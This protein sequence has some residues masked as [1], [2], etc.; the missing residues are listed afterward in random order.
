[1]GDNVDFPVAPSTARIATDEVDLRGNDDLVQ[2]PF[3]KIV[4]GS[5][6]GTNRLSVGS[7]GEAFTRP[8]RQHYSMG[9]GTGL[10]MP[11]TAG[12]YDAGDCLSD[13][14]GFALPPGVYSLA[15]VKIV[16]GNLGDI[17][18]ELPDGL[19]L[20]V[21]N[22]AAATPPTWA[23]DGDPF[24]PSLPGGVGSEALAMEAIGNFAPLY[25]TQRGYVISEDAGKIIHVNP[26]FDSLRLI[27]F[28]TEAAT[29]TAG[30]FLVIAGII[31][32]LGGPAVGS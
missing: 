25:G 30:D 2:V 6:G 21:T 29:F 26:G 13:G 23:G 5:D 18:G 8:I 15:R 19:V 16:V 31:E 11:L 27:P 4:D 1:M 12:S 9:G 14:Y 7:G 17:P 10:E 28:T 3:G 24:V 22:Y 20:A 32:R